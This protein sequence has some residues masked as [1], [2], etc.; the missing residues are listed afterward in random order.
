MDLCMSLCSSGK[1]A[2]SFRKWLRVLV[3]T[4]VK[5]YF[6]ISSLFTCCVPSEPTTT[7]R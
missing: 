3:V 2:T 1:K 7:I 6:A 4:K 5:N